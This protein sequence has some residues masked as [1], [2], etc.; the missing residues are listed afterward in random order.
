MCTARGGSYAAVRLGAL[1]RR[2]CPAGPCWERMGAAVLSTTF[3]CT[4]SDVA[5]Q[6]AMR[7]CVAATAYPPSDCAG[8]RLY[9]TRASRAPRLVP[10][11]R[12]SCVLPHCS[13][14]TLLSVS[15]PPPQPFRFFLLRFSQASQPAPSLRTLSYNANQ[16][17]AT[18]EQQQTVARILGTNDFYKIFNVPPNAGRA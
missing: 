3:R 16:N 18:Q 12:T 5:F 6:P 14:L 4:S 7:G 13:H 10:L 11:A 15:P 2:V 17:M 1:P 9:L 8:R